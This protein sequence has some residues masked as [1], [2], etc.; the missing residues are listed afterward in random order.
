MPIIRTMILITTLVVSFLVCCML[1]VMLGWSIVRAAA[2]TYFYSCEHI[3]NPILDFMY[4]HNC[5]NIGIPISKQHLR[6]IL[7]EA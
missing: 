6:L 4:V 1:E 7:L 3:Y 5:K 2:R